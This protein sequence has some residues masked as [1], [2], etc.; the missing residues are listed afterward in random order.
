M[1]TKLFIHNDNQQPFF[2]PKLRLCIALLCTFAAI[3]L[4]L[5]LNVKASWEFT[6]MFRA[7]KMLS[8]IIVAICI[9]T[10]T[11]LFQTLSNNRII[12]PAIM[13]FDSLY[14]L[15]QSV[16]V[17]F[18]GALQFNQFNPYLKWLIEVSLLV[19][20]ASMLFQWL[21]VKKQFNVYLLVLI[22]V[23]CGVFFQSISALLMRMMNPTDFSVLQD[24]LFASFNTVDQHLMIISGTVVCA[25]FAYIWRNHNNYD[26]MA[27]SKPLAINLGVNYQKL[28]RNTIIIISALVGL[29]TALVGPLAFL[30]LLVVNLAYI[31]CGSHLHRYLLPM[32]VLVA[33]TTLIGGDVLLQHVLAYNTQLSIIIQFV[34]GLFFIVLVLRKK[35]L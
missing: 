8:F 24:T 14:I 33:I 9:S 1:L 15:I 5:T 2:S 17:F 30:G 19:F 23:V 18:L 11:L 4:F 27:L 13:G 22:G 21:F 31:T 25:I 10:S 28:S 16:L 20:A 35:V 7:K 12:T 3:T 6:L 32:S 26:V 34:G 29:S